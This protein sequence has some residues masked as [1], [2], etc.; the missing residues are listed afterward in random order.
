MCLSQLKD[1]HS[2][3][4]WLASWEPWNFLTRLG[5]QSPEQSWL[6]AIF[7]QDYFV[8]LVPIPEGGD[9]NPRL[10][11]VGL[12][13]SGFLRSFWLQQRIQRWSC[14]ELEKWAKVKPARKESQGLPRLEEELR[15]KFKSNGMP[16]LLNVILII[17]QRR[18]LEK[19]R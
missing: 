10:D 12:G 16:F 17:S 11:W 9:P 19:G 15:Q 7:S 8:D 18:S 14:L 4:E 5:S 1:C 2:P 13:G 6:R 3:S